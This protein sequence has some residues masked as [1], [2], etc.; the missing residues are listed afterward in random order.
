MAEKKREDGL[1]YHLDGKSEEYIKR[2]GKRY[3]YEWFMRMKV[4]ASYHALL[5][6]IKVTKMKLRREMAILAATSIALNLIIS[7][8]LRKRK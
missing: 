7:L 4:D 2:F 3:C 6:Q 8:R 5:Q 1:Q